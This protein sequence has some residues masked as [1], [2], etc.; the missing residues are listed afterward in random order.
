MNKEG[1]TLLEML[2]VLGTAGALFAVTVPSLASSHR[3]WSVRAASAQFASAHALARATAIRFA[4]TAELHVDVTGN[5][6]WVE[7]DTSSTGGV[8]DTIG[9]MHSF[10]GTGVT[11]SANRSLL[12]FDARGMTTSQGACDD[13][14]AVIVFAAP[15]RQDTI[16]T[17]LLGK[18][19][20]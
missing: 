20:P 10:E 3:D 1:L 18:L 8:R 7:V 19:I 9:L 16:R 13:A 12:C 14:D 6:F 17:T 5:Q 4:G 15:G 2:I 11:L